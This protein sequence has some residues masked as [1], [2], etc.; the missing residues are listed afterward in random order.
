MIKKS[1]HFPT[2]RIYSTETNMVVC[3]KSF[4]QLA[5]CMIFNTKVF[6]SCITT[7]QVFKK[8]GLNWKPWV[9]RKMRILRGKEVTNKFTKENWPKKE[10]CV[11]FSKRKI[12]TIFVNNVISMLQYN[13]YKYCNVN[14]SLFIQCIC[15]KSMAKKKMCFVEWFWHHLFMHSEIVKWIWNW[16][17]SS[18]T[19]AFECITWLYI[20]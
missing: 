11:N 2:S 17:T 12:L 19:S 10:E 16:N 3:V 18:D 8:T 5:K 7:Q 20:N 6:L 9:L 13:Y 14:T 1:L 4:A 15:Y